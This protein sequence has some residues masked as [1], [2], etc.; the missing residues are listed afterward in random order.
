MTTIYKKLQDVRVELAAA[1]LKKSGKNKF[2]GYDYFELG[3]F[4]PTAMS[5]MKK[6]GLCGVISY[7]LETASLSIHDTEANGEPVIITTPMSTAAL[8][9]C[10][11]VQNLGA[12]QTYLR[13]YLWITALE[14]TEHDALDVGVDVD[15]AAKKTT[16][17]PKA[18]TPPAKPAAP[19]DDGDLKTILVSLAAL[20]SRAKVP[21]ME[22]KDM[23]AAAMFYRDL[24][25][26]ADPINTTPKKVSAALNSKKTQQQALDTI[27]KYYDHC[28]A[29]GDAA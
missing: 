15:S 19:D 5:L 28:N 25:M 21:L 20:C 4:I 24:M 22:E 18:I 1:S 23:Q 26:A 16:P 13:R 8:K 7:G 3:D 6:Q 27:T 10:H 17:S 14:L 12:V 2:S 9:G 29:K 11:E